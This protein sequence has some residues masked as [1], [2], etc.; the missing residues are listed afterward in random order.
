MATGPLA[1]P[2]TRARRLLSLGGR[3]EALVKSLAQS[4]VITG[5]IRTAVEGAIRA[6]PHM[7]DRA[8]VATFSGMMKNAGK[9]ESRE[10]ITEVLLET[11]R[12]LSSPE[13]K[14]S[15][16]RLVRRIVRQ[17]RGSLAGRAAFIKRYGVRP[18]SFLVIS[19]SMRCNLRC[20]G[21]Y[22]GEYTR[23]DDMPWET[24]SRVVGEARDMGIVF[25]V[26][27]GGEPFFSENVLR[28]W[29]ENPDISF[30]VYTN[31][32]LIDA[33]MARRL[34]K[35]GNVYPSISVE[36]FAAETDARRGAGTHDRI[37]AAMANLRREGVLFGFS[38]TV[39]QSNNDLVSS[40]EFID[41]YADKGCFL[42]WYFNYIPIG[43]TPD[44]SLMPTPEQ[45]LARWQRL[46]ELRKTKPILLADF[47]CDGA[48][49]GGCIAGGRSYLHINCNGDAEPCV[50]AHFAADNIKDKSLAQVMLSPLFTAIRARQPYSS[51]LLRPCM[52]IDNPEVLRAVVAEGGAHPTHAGAET[53]IGPLSAHLDDYA[54][55][56]AR[57]ADPVWAKE[58]PETEVKR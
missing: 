36:G 9:A 16:A 53:I 47:W 51:N 30:L 50:F 41:Y 11:K 14:Q 43:R 56:Y 20:Y 58:H 38:A 27:S 8:F 24:L 28:M 22:A 37:L 5:A 3:P 15:T 54:G 39:V 42:G 13:Y 46:R 55:R 31:G 35:M 45:R 1:Q 57:L 48:L 10:F 52:I 49:A 34:A 23:A 26:V 12:L 17:H 6:A 32:T 29:E 33:P 25:I 18:L 7:S 19:P 2:R 21:C 40:P 4:T 44:L